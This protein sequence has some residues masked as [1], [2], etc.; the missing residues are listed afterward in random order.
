M[1][2]LS[3]W[4]ENH[5]ND[6]KFQDNRIRELFTAGGVGFNIHKLLGVPTSTAT[7]TDA[8]LPN[9]TNQSEKNIQDLLFLE[10]RDRKYETNIYTLRG[11]YTIQDLDF[12]LTQFAL[13]VSNDTLFLTFHI[14]D[15][16]ERMG[17]RI[18]VG[19]VIEFHHLRDYNPLDPNDQIPVALRKY[20]VVQEAT[21]AAEG[22]A[23]TW[24]PHLWRVKVK[25]MVDS[26]E[27]QEILNQPAVS[28]DKVTEYGPIKDY[29]STLNTQLEINDAVLQQASNDV[30]KSG[31][32]TTP[33]YVLPTTPSG[34]PAVPI[35]YGSDSTT[36]KADFD[37]VTADYTFITPQRD[38]LGY[39]VGDGLAPNGYPVLPGTSFPENPIEG[40]YVLRTDFVPNRLFRYDG[41]RWVAI[42][43]AIRANINS[44]TN[45]T[46]HGTFVN[47][48]NITRT[49]HG[50]L[51]SERVAL[52]EIF[53][54][55]ED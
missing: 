48:A 18:I 6:Y 7:S 13:M 33:L 34:E 30:P 54:I 19:D 4:R 5:T 32:D 38:M 27:F 40:T 20:Y 14:N 36:I 37:N 10:N 46:Q 1:P 31:Y 2:R 3:L 52:S 43:D 49:Q 16:I 29:I 8:T 25:P 44:N 9:Y 24:W 22:F 53:K 11:H 28:D 45:N 41:V 39:L 42:E 51:Q 35:S 47:N 26:Q 55:R 21:R 15:M 50:T 23:P 12:A 17:R